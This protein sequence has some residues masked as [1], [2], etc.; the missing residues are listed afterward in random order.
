MILSTYDNLEMKNFGKEQIS[1]CQNSGTGKD[2]EV[3]VPL[4]ATLRSL[5]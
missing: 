3:G 1:G 4:S 5:W 2:E